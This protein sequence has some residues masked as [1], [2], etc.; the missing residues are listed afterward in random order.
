MGEIA[1]ILL[2]ILMGKRA[3][4]STPDAAPLPGSTSAADAAAK[5]TQAAADAAQH[6][7]NTGKPDDAK[8]AHQKA[9]TAQVLTQHAAAQAAPAPW[10]QVVPRGLPAWPA[11]WQFDNPPSP[12]VV[13]RAWQLLAPL[14][15]RGSGARQVEQTDG[16]WITY[17]ATPNMGGP[18]KKGV[19]AYR[20][21]DGLPTTSSSTNPARATS[22]A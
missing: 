14:W 11:G 18:G 10:P 1:F 20:I 19:A 7:A 4:S 3:S 8:R 2:M 6:A 13:T 12:G 9:Q 5:A 22:N 15:K 16:K 17:V 21:R